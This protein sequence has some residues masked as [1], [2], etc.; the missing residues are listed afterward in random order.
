MSHRKWRAFVPLFTAEVAIQMRMVRG[1][2]PPAHVGPLAAIFNRILT[3]L[4]KEGDDVHAP[5]L[6][7]GVRE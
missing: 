3:E 6:Q 7:M 5:V 2:G 4:E 1:R